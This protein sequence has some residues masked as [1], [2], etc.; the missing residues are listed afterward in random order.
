MHFNVITR[1]KYVAIKRVPLSFYVSLMGSKVPFQLI[2]NTFLWYRLVSN[3]DTKC[4]YAFG[5]KTKNKKKTSSP[6]FGNFPPSFVFNEIYFFYVANHLM[7]A[8]YASPTVKILAD[9][10]LNFDTSTYLG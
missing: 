10:Q 6:T 2:L 4:I 5:R 8:F 7:L 1:T 9:F 3:K